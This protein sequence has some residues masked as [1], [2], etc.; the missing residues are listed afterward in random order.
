MGR[1]HSKNIMKKIILMIVIMSLIEASIFIIMSKVLT[2]KSIENLLDEYSNKNVELYAEFLGEFFKNRMHEIG[3]YAESPIVKTMDWNQIEPYLKNEY[4]KYINI[5]DNFSVADVNGKYWNTVGDIVGNIK[6][7]EHFKAVMRGETLV[8]NAVVSRTTGNRAVIIAAPIRNNNGEIIGLISGSINLIKLSGIIEKLKYNYPNSYSYITD[9]NG[10]ILAHPDIDYI[11]KQNITVESDVISEQIVKISSDILNNKS[12]SVSYS[13]NGIESINFFYRIPNTD[14]WKLVIK[15]PLSHWQNPIGNALKGLIII[16]IGAS[17]A[18]A[19][20]GNLVA[21]SISNPIVRLKEVFIRATTGDLTVRSD[22]NSEDEIGQAAKSFN[23]MMDTIC[24]LTYYDSLTGL[25]N[26]LMFYNQINC[27]IERAIREKSKVAIVILDIDKF[28]N[29]NNTLGHDVG[30]KLLKS[31][32]ERI[33]MCFGKN[34]LISR[35]GEDKFALLLADI[36]D[37]KKVIETAQEMLYLIKKP[38]IVDKYRFYITAGIGIAMY[39]KDAQDS[40]TLFRNAYSAMQK[41]KKTGQDTYQFYDRSMN[42]KLIDQLNLDSSMH[43]ALNRGEFHICYQPLINAMTGEISGCEALLRWNNPELGIVPP[44]KF[45][46][47]A[48]TNG[49]IIPIGEW[50]LRTACRQN[51]LWQ[52]AGYQPIRISVN[53]SAVQLMQENFVDMISDV[54]RETN[55]SPEYLE[56]EI[57]ESV[58]A[59]NPEYVSPI[60]HKLKKMGVHIAL[61]D[62]G[63]GYS[64]LNYLKSFPINNLKIDKSFIQDIDT[65]SINASIVTIILTIGHTLK[66][67]VTAEGVENETQ[68]NILKKECCDLIQ[69]FLFSKPVNKE[70]FEL[71]LKKKPAD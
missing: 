9:R 44:A 36:E 20:L 70:E 28:E 13:F 58:A 57:T 34:T 12:G 2:E 10:L 45:I 17:L 69:G 48:E 6:D 35:I 42:D 4:K 1:L 32:A 31:V 64:S 11:M 68:Y 63:T 56:L 46:P 33:R 59:K 71:L 41:S 39:P 47:I 43:N 53:I 18:V 51:K 66:L 50:V 38:W 7:R 61:D 40:K 21:Q 5:Y 8:S 62:F 52:D 49:L 22:I 54:L 60:L 55:L 3:I 14:G 25:P 23:K 19:L 30:D 29:I 15:V 24:N 27:E 37:E 65:N 16:G 26:K 67:N